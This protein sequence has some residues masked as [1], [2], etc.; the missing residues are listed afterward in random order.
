[1]DSVIKSHKDSL[2]YLAKGQQ[3]DVPHHLLR[4]LTTLVC[5]HKGK[6]FCMPIILADPEVNR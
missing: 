6:M 1:M 2:V 5:I 4:P 3:A